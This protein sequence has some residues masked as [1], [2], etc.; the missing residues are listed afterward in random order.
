M[1]SL[2]EAILFLKPSILEYVGDKSILYG[3]IVMRC[4]MEMTKI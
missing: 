1:I 3:G 4:N 2:G